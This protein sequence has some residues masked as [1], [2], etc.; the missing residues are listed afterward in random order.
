MPRQGRI[1]LPG[2]LYHVMARGIE[3]RRIFADNAD[4]VAFIQRLAE[5]LKTHQIKCYAWTLMPNHI[6]LLL[7]PTTRPLTPFLHS[8]L[9]GYAVHFNRRHKRAG[10]LFQN[11]YRSILCQKERYFL[12]LIRYIHLNPVRAGLVADS[13]ALNRY[14]WSGHAALAGN[15]SREWQAVLEVLCCFDRTEGR[16]RRKYVEF[17]REGETQKVREELEGGGLRRSQQGWKTGTDG[18]RIG[19]ERILGESMFVAEVLEGP[20]GGQSSAVIRSKWP[21]ERITQMVCDYFKIAPHQ[22]KAKWK[23]HRAGAA[24]A[25]LAYLLKTECCINGQ[26]IGKQLGMTRAGAA[27]LI[28]RGEAYCRRQ[29]DILTFKQRPQNGGA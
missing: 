21:M 9:T 3:R 15:R 18:D 4:R 14:A 7:S 2:G 26:E 29:P 24:K 8:L 6:H 16:A 11:R 13:K 1:H 20:R 23:S 19:D 5:G 22:L 12:E 28:R 27:Y 25:V 10:H 17:I